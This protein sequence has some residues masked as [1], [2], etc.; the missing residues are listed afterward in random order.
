MLEQTLAL[1]RACSTAT[2][3]IREWIRLFTAFDVM[4]TIVADRITK[5]EGKFH[6]YKRCLV[7]PEY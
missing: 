4:K 7:L 1:A 3:D 5:L 2:V 6:S